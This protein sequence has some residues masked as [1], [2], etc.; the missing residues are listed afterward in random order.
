MDTFFD[1]LFEQL[2]HQGFSMTL[3][4][5]AIYFIYKDLERQKVQN[6]ASQEQIVQYLKDDRAKLIQ[7]VQELSDVVEQNT[8]ILK[9]IEK[10]L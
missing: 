5:T 1:F 8:A 2:R 4:F 3:L 7:L 9:A 10:K 6:K